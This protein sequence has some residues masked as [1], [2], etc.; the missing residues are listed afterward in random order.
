MFDL[1][2]ERWE[3]E[4][5]GK[6]EITSKRGVHPSS[7]KRLRREGVLVGRDLKNANDRTYETIYLVS[8]NKNFLK[9]YPKKK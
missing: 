1:G 6:Y 4:F 8:E 9:D 2:K 5:F 7:I 3:M